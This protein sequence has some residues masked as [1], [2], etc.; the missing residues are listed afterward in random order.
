M[1]QE[2]AFVFP[3]P[4]Y[5]CS[6][7]HHSSM[8]PPLVVVGEKGILR[9]ASPWQLPPQSPFLG[10]SN[11]PTLDQEEART[12]LCRPEGIIIDEDNSGEARHHENLTTLNRTN[13]SRGRYIS[14][15]FAI[16]I[17]GLL[18]GTSL[19]FAIINMSE[20]LLDMNYLFGVSLAIFLA[21]S[22]LA[23]LYYAEN[24]QHREKKWLEAGLIIALGP[25]LRF[26]FSVRLLKAKLGNAD[27]NQSQDFLDLQAIAT[28]TRVI[29]GVFQGS[30]QIVWL[31]YLIA[32]GIHPLPLP[33]PDLKTT[34]PFMDSLGNYISLPVLSSFG[35]YPTMAVLVKNLFQYWRQHHLK[36]T[37]EDGSTTV[38]VEENITS[39]KTFRR[40]LW[41]SLFILCACLF[42]LGTYALLVLHFN[43][44]FL[45][46]VGV[47]LVGSLLLHIL[48]RG[49]DRFYVRTSQMDVLLTAVCCCLVPTPVNSHVREHNLLQVH[50]AFTNLLL[51]LVLFLAVFFSLDYNRPIVKRSEK[52]DYPSSTFFNLTFTTS[53]LV[54]L[55]AL[56]YAI[57][58]WDTILSDVPRVTIFWRNKVITPLAKFL[59]LA[60]GILVA[61]HLLLTILGRM[62]SNFC[63]P[64]VILHGCF[65]PSPN[66]SQLSCH[67][68]FQPSQ[69]GFITCAWFFGP[70]GVVEITPLYY[71]EHH[72]VITLRSYS[73]LACVPFS[74]GQAIPHLPTNSSSISVQ[75]H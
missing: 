12:P 72:Q 23:L 66:G 40:C 62:S 10:P 44:F 34:Q 43:F 64:P 4:S 39:F 19:I 26:L 22:I 65:S 30:L 25:L 18:P 17:E 13:A 53:L 46:P 47:C 56:L 11:R 49:S 6:P 54:P 51:L 24:M 41:L 35:L 52:V 58:K 45:L 68:S 16:M 70:Q 74:Q 36:A 7:R 75:G 20:F 63:E 1:I 50:S 32:R 61:A 37:T 9:T 59:I 33:Y 55:S 67:P 42:R 14:N 3:S 71:H 48:L 5:L 8:V 38:L 15:L 69:E 57:F 29:D 28:A 60:T 2:T 73:T 27:L 21:P 31:F